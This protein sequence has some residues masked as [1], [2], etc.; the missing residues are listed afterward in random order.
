M[1]LEQFC[2]FGQAARRFRKLAQVIDDRLTG[3]NPFKLGG[4]VRRQVTAHPPKVTRRS[5][6]HEEARGKA[7]GVRLVDAEQP[8]VAIVHIKS[9]GLHAGQLKIAVLH[10][11]TIPARPFVGKVNVPSV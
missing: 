2:I 4:Q 6:N 1:L 8:V 10:A 3:G 7:V 5:P 9:V 11:S